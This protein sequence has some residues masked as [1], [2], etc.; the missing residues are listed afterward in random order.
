M[1][2]YVMI[3]RQGDRR[4]SADEQQRRG[5]EVRAW[6]QAQNGAGRKLDPRM[7]GDDIHRANGAAPLNGD[8]PVIALLFLEARDI[9]DART[10]ANSHPG[11]RYGVNIELRPWTPPAP[12]KPQ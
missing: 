9:E 5:D 8:H 10:V 11:L 3:F 1:N 7:L 2:Q 4:L 12:A 6:A